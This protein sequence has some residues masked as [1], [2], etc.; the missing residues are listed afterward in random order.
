M[1]AI[2]YVVW[3]AVLFALAMGLFFGLRS[4]KII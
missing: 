2:V 1:G 3:L 4:A